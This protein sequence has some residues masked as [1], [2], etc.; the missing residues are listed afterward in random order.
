MRWMLVAVLV[1]GCAPNGFER[2]PEQ[3][4]ARWQRCANPVMDTRCGS[5]KD[6]V[7]RA[8]C[9]R[10]LAENYSAAPSSTERL[11]WLKANGCPPAMVNPDGY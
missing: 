2:L 4:R 1:V 10:D 8:M 9:G 5:D 3:D 11:R 6:M 7:Y